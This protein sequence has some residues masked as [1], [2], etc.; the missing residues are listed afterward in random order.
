[1]ADRSGLGK[2]GYLFGGVTLAVM[3]MAFTVVLGHVEGRLAIDP[4]PAPA[5]SQVAALAR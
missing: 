5:P 4:A 1:M 2:L 3:L